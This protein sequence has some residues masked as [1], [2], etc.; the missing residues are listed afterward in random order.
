MTVRMP[1]R[2]CVHACVCWGVHLGCVRAL[3]VRC[4]RARMTVRV[5]ALVRV[6]VRE[7]L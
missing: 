1:A 4:A 6:C 2:M 5:R 3:R 7:R